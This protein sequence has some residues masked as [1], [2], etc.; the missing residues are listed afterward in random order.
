MDLDP[1][2]P[3]HDGGRTSIAF[4]WCLAGLLLITLATF[5]RCVTH[6]FAEWDDGPMLSQNPLLNPV[7]PA[8]VRA[9]W[10]APVQFLYTPLAYTTWAATSL[11]ARTTPDSRGVT[12]NPMAFHVLNLLLHL[13]TVTLV[14]QLLRRLVRRDLPA[15]IGAAV[16]AIHP[17]QTEPIAWIAGMNN[18]LAG[19]FVVAAMLAFV[20]FRQAPSKPR[21]WY[22][23]SLTFLILALLSKPTA[24]VAPLLVLILDLTLLATP[25]RTAAKAIWPFAL[26]VVPF[27]IIGRASQPSENVAAPVLIERLQIAA[28]TVGFYTHKL[29]LPWPLLM[30]YSRTPESVLARGVSLTTWTTLAAIL[31]FAVAIQRRW[32]ATAAALLLFP[33]AILPTSGLIPFSYQLYS[34]VADRYV[35][36]AMLAPALAVAFLATRLKPQPLA[37]V[38]TVLV[39][40]MAA[41][42]F[43]QAGI[44]RN[45]FTLCTHTVKHNDRSLAAHGAL[46]AAYALAGQLD[47][48]ES[49]DRAV[50]DVRPIDEQAHYNLGKVLESRRQYA[51]AAG[52]FRLAEEYG[53]T[54]PDLLFDYGNALYKSGALPQAHQ[55]LTR[56]VQANPDDNRSRATLGW[57]TAAA[58]D[59]DTA[60]HLFQETLRRDPTSSLA[61]AGLQRVKQARQ[62]GSPN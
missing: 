21:R 62:G 58:G 53:F 7:T 38:G 1:A 39:A 4:R 2:T 14:F 22:A 54:S 35:Y 36:L 12:L 28:D 57:V 43:T 25:W 42:S 27:V 6:E 15:A 13:I 32:R 34:T 61:V 23:V 17:L 19:L 8:H 56:A 47:L 29:V 46:G 41:V 26:V 44:W 37:A 51:E 40:V 45:T 50:L 16:F 9:Y 24:I 52:H 3:A 31:L 18:L 5:G 30:D 10:A 55:I 11:F 33:I 20:V 59:L 49:H 48:A 60:E